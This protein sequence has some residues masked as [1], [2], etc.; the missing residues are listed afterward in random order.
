LK[1]LY[2]L[3]YNKNFVC[4]RN[5]ELNCFYKLFTTINQFLFHFS[6]LFWTDRHY[7]RI[8]SSNLDGTGRR[9]FVGDFIGQP[10]ALSI[11]FQ[12]RQLCWTDAGTETGYL[13]V[14]PKIGRSI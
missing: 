12:N 2:P 11:D 3:Q 4:L 10:N 14:N 7:P 1:N 8:E 13:T 6:Q 9:I 5:L